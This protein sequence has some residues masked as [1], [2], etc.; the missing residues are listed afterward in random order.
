MGTTGSRTI[1]PL[2]VHLSLNGGALTGG[3]T[4]CGISLVTAGAESSIVNGS[5][6][7]VVTAGGV[8]LTFFK[9]RLLRLSNVLSAVL[10]LYD[11][12]AGW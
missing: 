10:I 2:L 9:C 5:S 7:V 3:G 1:R 12:G 8:S 11:L 6:K 4:T